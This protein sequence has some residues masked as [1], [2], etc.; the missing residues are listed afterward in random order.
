MAYSPTQLQLEQMQAEE[1]LNRKQWTPEKF[2]IEVKNYCEKYDFEIIEGLIEY[3]N[4]HDL[5]L[6][7][8]ANDLMSNRLYALLQDDAEAKRLIVKSKRLTFE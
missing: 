1:A 2:L 4:E 7:F 3:C 6:E 8:V 5:D